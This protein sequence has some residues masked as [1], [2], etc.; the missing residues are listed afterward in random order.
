MKVNVG[1]ADARIRMGAAI[2]LAVVALIFNAT[3]VVA[4]SLAAV[5]AVLA[6]TSLFHQ[7]PLYSVIGIDTCHGEHSPHSP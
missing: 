1:K 3:P 7:C 4:L 5:A 2:V 6:A